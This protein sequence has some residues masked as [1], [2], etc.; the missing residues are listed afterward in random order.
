MAKT[1]QDVLTDLQAILLAPVRAGAPACMT[2]YNRLGDAIT[3]LNATT[4]VDV[5]TSSFTVEEV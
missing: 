4:T 2:A 1:I 5:K 3:A